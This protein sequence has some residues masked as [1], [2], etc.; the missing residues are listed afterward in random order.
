M[1]E[2]ERNGMRVLFEAS[3][4]NAKKG[5]P[6]SDFSDWLEWAELLGVKLSL[7]YKNRTQ[8]IEFIKYIDQ[9]LFDKDMR[10]KPERVNFIAAFCDGSRL[11]SN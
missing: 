7:P 10:N 11:S 5:R 1:S 3:Y 6:Y 2:T 8:S 4:L 9:A